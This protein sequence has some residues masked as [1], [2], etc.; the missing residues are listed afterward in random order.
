M[1]DRTATNTLWT[2]TL[3]ELLYSALQKRGDERRILKVVHGLKQR[4]LGAGYLLH[5][6]REELGEEAAARFK[7]IMLPYSAPVE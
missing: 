7:R 4:G 1:S 6:V 3:L 2:E 5:K